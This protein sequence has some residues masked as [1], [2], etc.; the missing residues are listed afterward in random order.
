MRKAL[1]RS[2]NTRK[3]TQIH[4]VTFSKSFVP[5]WIVFVNDILMLWGEFWWIDFLQ[6]P[7]ISSI[8]DQLAFLNYSIYC[9]HFALSLSCLLSVKWRMAF[10]SS[11]RIVEKTTSRRGSRIR[12][13]IFLTGCENTSGNIPDW[14]Q[15]NL[16]VIYDRWLYISR[17]YINRISIRMLINQH[18]E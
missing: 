7:L 5:H 18:S 6:S 12:F 17:F 8:I 1:Q 9:R 13:N 14:T 10:S 15:F 11:K 2:S 16:F 3:S 4:P